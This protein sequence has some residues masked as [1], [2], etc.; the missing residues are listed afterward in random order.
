LL[1]IACG[2]SLCFVMSQVA[3]ADNRSPLLWAAITFLLCLISLLIPV[4]FFRLLLPMLV[5][6]V[7]MFVCNLIRPPRL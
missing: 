4:P 3:N 1:E 7:A 5:V 6:L 2:I